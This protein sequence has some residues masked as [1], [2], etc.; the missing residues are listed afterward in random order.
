MSCKFV[1]WPWPPS[2]KGHLAART[3]SLARSSDAD[4][5]ARLPLRAS[6]QGSPSP[7]P[8]PADA[9]RRVLR[10]PDGRR[11]KL[12]TLRDDDGGPIAL[13]CFGVKRYILWLKPCTASGGVHGD[14]CFYC[15]RFFHS[16]VKRSA[17]KGVT[18]GQY[19]K[20]LGTSEER[21]TKHGQMAL[22]LTWGDGAQ[23]RKHLRSHRL[24]VGG[25]TSIVGSHRIC[26]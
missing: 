9:P 21:L 19:E 24:G 17:E 6:P 5:S 16:K 22:C 15:G 8:D 18:L 2:G 1:V 10:C 20:A 3:D 26:N 13:L 4:S 12:C 7:G 14:V 23:R 25:E 11:C